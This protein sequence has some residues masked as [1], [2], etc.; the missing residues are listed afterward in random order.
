MQAFILIVYLSSTLGDYTVKWSPDFA[1]CLQQKTFEL[2][3]HPRAEAVCI[4]HSGDVA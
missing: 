1:S 2:R 3:Y 4:P